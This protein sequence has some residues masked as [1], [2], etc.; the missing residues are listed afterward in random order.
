[1][2]ALALGT[3]LAAMG[4]LVT[5]AACQL[6]DAIG[7]GRFVAGA[8]AFLLAEP[9]VPSDQRKTGVG[10]VVEHQLAG[11]A[12]TVT[13]EA[14]FVGKLAAVGVGV[15][16]TSTALGWHLFKL[17]R[18]RATVAGTASG[19]TM[20]AGQRELRVRVV[21]Q[22]GAHKAAPVAIGAGKLR[23]PA[24]VWVR[25]TAGAIR[26]QGLCVSLV[27]RLAFELGVFAPERQLGEVVV[28]GD[29]FPGALRRVTLVA[30]PETFIVAMRV[31]T[32]AVGTVTWWL[33]RA[34][35]GI[36][37]TG[38]T[39]RAGVGALERECLFGVV[40]GHV[41]AAHPLHSARFVT[42]RAALQILL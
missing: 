5:I 9:R 13:I 42:E 33:P 23:K 12:L 14:G 18:V 21:V 11:A 36:L 6:A 32:V 30:P 4:I 28:E 1:V 10:V 20:S 17:V 22:G 7:A 3:E 38:G 41:A 35:V 27:T 26:I 19:V 8:A 40:E 29:L 24:A 2:A 34:H 39:A 15:L 25:V 16:V 37:V 31:A